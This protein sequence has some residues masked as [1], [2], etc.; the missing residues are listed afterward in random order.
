MRIIFSDQSAHELHFAFATFSYHVRHTFVSRPPHVRITSATRSCR[1]RHALTW[2]ILRNSRVANILLLSLWLKS[3]S[4]RHYPI[5]P[6]SLPTVWMQRKRPIYM[7]PTKKKQ[8]NFDENPL[9]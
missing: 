5:H 8:K 7:Q 2:R 6:A 1:V 4:Q 3:H 9:Y